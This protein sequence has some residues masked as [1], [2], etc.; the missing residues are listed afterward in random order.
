MWRTLAQKYGD[1]VALDDPH[2][3]PHVQ[4]TYREVRCKA[5]ASNCYCEGLSIFYFWCI[6]LLHFHNTAD[7]VYCTGPLMNVGFCLLFWTTNSIEKE[8]LLPCGMPELRLVCFRWSRLSLTSVKGCA[9]MGSNQGIEW[10]SSPTTPIDG[11]SRIKVRFQPSISWW[12]W[13]LFSAHWN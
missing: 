2:R 13:I 10:A 7:H 4:M 8:M 9:C 3:N 12:R 1:L 5:S 11:S 6:G